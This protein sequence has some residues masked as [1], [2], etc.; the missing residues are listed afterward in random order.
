MSVNAIL[1]KLIYVMICFSKVDLRKNVL[2]VWPMSQRASPI[3]IPILSIDKQIRVHFYAFEPYG[4]H[5]QIV[6]VAKTQERQIQD[7]LIH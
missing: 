6:S 7:D 2:P 3:I 1:D 4:F 5:G